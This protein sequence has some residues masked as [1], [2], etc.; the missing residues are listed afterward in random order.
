MADARAATKTIVQAWFSENGIGYD[1][2]DGFVDTLNH[3]QIKQIIQ[4]LETQG[5]QLSVVSGVLQISNVNVST[6][7]VITAN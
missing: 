1:G 3:S 5:L 6:I 7:D 4:M 2:T